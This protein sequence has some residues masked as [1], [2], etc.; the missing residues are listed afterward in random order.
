MIVFEWYEGCLISNS[1]L[2]VRSSRIYIDNNG[3]VWPTH[4]SSSSQNE[5]AGDENGLVCEQRVQNE[6]AIVGKTR[7]VDKSG[8]MKIKNIETKQNNFLQIP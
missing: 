4:P 2:T 1:L 5:D 3:S 8:C 7:K 6:N